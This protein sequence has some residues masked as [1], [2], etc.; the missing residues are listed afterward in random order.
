MLGLRVDGARVGLP[1]ARRAVTPTLAVVGALLA[2]SPALASAPARAAP[3]HR[4][5]HG[6]STNWSGYVVTGSGPYTTV[7]A[8]WT[9]PAVNCASNKPS[10]SAFWVG[11]DGDTTNTVEQTGT[12]ANCAHGSATYGAWFEMFPK[13]P[14]NYPNPVAPG[15]VF[16][17]SVSYAG[18]GRFQMTLTDTTQGWSQTTSQKKKSAKRGSAEVIAEAPSSRKGVLA[19]ADFGTISFTGASV[20]GSLL[21]SSTPGIEP[22]TMSSGETVKATPS[23]I[24]G[25]G[26]SDAWQHE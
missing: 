11:L 10:F 24:S 7:S 6:V 13:R 20:N 26:F 2:A 8:G 23:A 4:I 14:V 15:D 16:T 19:L 5:R 17:A 21:T 12:E 18:K 25:G 1:L 3:N 22:L 9:Q